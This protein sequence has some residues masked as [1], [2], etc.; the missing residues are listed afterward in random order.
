M[1]T[2]LSEGI[3]LHGSKLVAWFRSLVKTNN[4]LY[5]TFNKTNTACIDVL[6]KES[7]HCPANT[8]LETMMF[9]YW[10]IV[11]D[12][13]PIIKHHCFNVSCLLGGCNYAEAQCNSNEATL[14]SAMYAVFFFWWI[15]NFM[16]YI[17]LTFYMKLLIAAYTVYQ[18]IQKNTM[19]CCPS[20]T[21]THVIAITCTLNDR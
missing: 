18:H 1:N 11:C 20:L 5:S 19:L 2:I 4:F 15:M 17:T 13:G 8:T 14:V 12:A 3:G 7:L 6:L 10:P 21:L 9:Y 16:N